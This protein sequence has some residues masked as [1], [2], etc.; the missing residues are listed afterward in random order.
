MENNNKKICP[1]CGAEINEEAK[2]CRFCNN[3]LDDEIQCPFC[4]EKIKASAKKCRFCGEWLNKDDKKENTNKTEFMPKFEFKLK[5]I[6]FQKQQVL[7][8][9]ISVLVL[10][11]IG[12]I[13]GFVNYVPNCKSSSVQSKLKD[14]LTANHTEISDIVLDKTS[15]HKLKKLEKGY[16]CSINATIDETPTQIEYQYKKVSLSEYDMSAKFVLPNCFNPTVKE[17]LNGLIK[18][19]NSYNIKDNT[20][21]VTTSMEVQNDYDKAAVKYS[22]SADA[23][24]TAKPGKA[25]LLHS[26]DYDE[27][28]RSIKCRVD[29]K[30]YFCENGYTTCVG[31]TDVYSCEYKED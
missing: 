8:I 24:L 11:L 19:D 29:Y 3:W 10:F 2:K 14:Y 13:I 7:I 21:D 27:A 26:W 4:A 5:P 6:N 22:C 18:K 30:T 16:S 25:Y 23:E 15:A 28:T 17:I 12:L 31:L 20:S 1:F 9:G